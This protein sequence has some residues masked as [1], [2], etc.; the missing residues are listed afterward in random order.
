MTEALANGVTVICTPVGEIS[1]VLTDGLNATFVQP[2]DVKGIA[3]SLRRL[4]EQPALRNEL[5]G[6]GREIY[7]QSFSVAKFFDNIAAIHTRCFGIC[8]NRT[9]ESSGLTKAKL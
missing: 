8:A 5:E 9:H 7:E 6:N 4:L 1:N 3:T 2:G